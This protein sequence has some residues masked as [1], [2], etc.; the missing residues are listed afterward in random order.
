[1]ASAKHENKQCLPGAENSTMLLPNNISADDPAVAVLTLNW[2]DIELEED[3]EPSCTESLGSQDVSEKTPLTSQ[4]ELVAS[5]L[6]STG[7]FK[8]PWTAW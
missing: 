8:C 6:N 5:E 2:A 7:V 1:M 4:S 3:E